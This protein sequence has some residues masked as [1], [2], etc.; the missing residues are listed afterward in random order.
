[1]YEKIKEYLDKKDIP[2]VEKAISNY[3]KV[4]KET[5]NFYEAV[6]RMRDILSKD[7]AEK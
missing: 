6:M 2:T 4:V 1:L 3:N 5:D 7:D